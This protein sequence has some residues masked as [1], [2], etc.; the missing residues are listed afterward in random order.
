MDS[1]GKNTEVGYCALLQR[2]FPTQGLNPLLLSPALA[3]RFFTTSITWESHNNNIN[4][5]YICHFDVFLKLHN[6][7]NIV[8]QL[9]FNFK[10]DKIQTGLFQRERCYERPCVCVHVC[11]CTHASVSVL[12]CSCSGD[13]VRRTESKEERK[14]R[15]LHPQGGQSFSLMLPFREGSWVLGSG[16]R[17]LCF[18]GPDTLVLKATLG[19]GGGAWTCYSETYHLVPSSLSFSR[20]VHVSQ[21]HKYDFI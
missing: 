16:G 11:V 4:Y 20:P 13:D 8:N 19:K 18:H 1:P 15:G 5:I 9:S 6:I 7:V 14:Y 21:G 2:I 3:G 10:K 12:S 17:R